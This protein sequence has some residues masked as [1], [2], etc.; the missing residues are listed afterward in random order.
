MLAAI[1]DVSRIA[2]PVG[3]DS[4]MS[5]L[6]ARCLMARKVSTSRDLVPPA[7]GN[8]YAV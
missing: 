1:I 6:I 5:G 7:Q 2:H 4:T 8:V 3:F